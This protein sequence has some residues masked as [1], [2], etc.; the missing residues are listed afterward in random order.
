LSIKI[1]SMPTPI[2]SITNGMDF[3]VIIFSKAS[4]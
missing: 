3:G 1:I 4:T 2:S